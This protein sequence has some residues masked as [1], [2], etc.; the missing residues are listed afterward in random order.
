M[1][2]GFRLFG[3]SLLGAAATPAI[4]ALTRKAPI[5]APHVWRRSLLHLGFNLVMTFALIVVS[6]LLARVLP[7][8]THHALVRDITEALGAKQAALSA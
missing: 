4:L 1:H 5:E 3:A 8:A 6:C 7:Y 2:E